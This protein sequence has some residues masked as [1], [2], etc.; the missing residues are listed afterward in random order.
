METLNAEFLKEA[1]EPI[2]GVNLEEA[3]V[4]LFADPNPS[5]N[6][7]SV[8]KRITGLFFVAFYTFT[9]DHPLA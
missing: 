2:L 6:F 7:A 8:G 1:G 5:A 9:A 3:L 4:G